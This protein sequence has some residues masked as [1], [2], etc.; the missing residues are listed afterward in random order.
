[1]DHGVHTAEAVHVAGDTPGLLEVAQVADE[2]VGAAVDEVADG[3]EPVA[4]ANVDDDFVSVGE[5]RLS[6]RPSEAVRGAG[7]EDAPH[8]TLTNERGGSCESRPIVSASRL[9]KLRS[10]RVLS[11]HARRVRGSP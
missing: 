2:D 11:R 9:L 1:V 4:V 6:G 7:D 5:Q 3:F 10:P 8:Q